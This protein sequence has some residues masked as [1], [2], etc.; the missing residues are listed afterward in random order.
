[1]DKNFVD[2]L[3]LLTTLLLPM[4]FGYACKFLNIFP[5]NEAAVL[6]KFVV[7]ISVPF[8]IFKNL[9]QANIRSLG[10]FFPA[11]S[12]LIMLTVLFGI[13]AYYLS[14]R[15]SKD[16][17]EQNSYIFTVFLGN[18]VFLGWGVIHSFYGEQALTRG[19]FFTLL[20]WPALLSTGFWLIHLINKKKITSSP[21][22]DSS[23]KAIGDPAPKSGR[24]FASI[25]LRN[26]GIPVG[27]S[28]FAMGMNLL[29]VPVQPIIWGFV[30]KFA[31]FTIP[32]ILFAIGLNF[33]LKMPK[34]K[35]KILLAGS[36]SRLVLGI[37][38]GLVV[39]TITCLIFP[40][41]L[42]TRKVILIQSIMPSAAVSV[43][44][45]EYTLVDKEIQAGIIAVST[46]LSF[47][48]IPAWYII[49]ERF[50]FPYL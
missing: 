42:L 5:G 2:I 28:I 18:Y 35:L 13:S 50:L 47:I 1:M 32:M 44:F 41:D 20:S 12:A 4:A 6:Q 49:L 39:L 23:S 17:K 27:T 36:F 19:V 21:G 34:S 31:S 46:L 15:F 11:A 43:L 48:T 45:A 16:E 8:L 22:I 24:T 29:Q 33:K 14:R 9:Y 25:L 40:V 37:L 26:A 38:P 30:E 10:Q 3:T 7:K